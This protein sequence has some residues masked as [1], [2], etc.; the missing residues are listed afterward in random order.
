MEPD[1]RRFRAV[2]ASALLGL[3]ATLL[4]ATVRWVWSV[5]G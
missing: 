4:W 2:V 1:Q 5:I 3:G